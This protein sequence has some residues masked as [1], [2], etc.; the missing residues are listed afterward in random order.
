MMRH[1]TETLALVEMIKST[2]IHIKYIQ[3]VQNDFGDFGVDL[4]DN[5]MTRGAET[6]VKVR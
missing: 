4:H 2:H 1:L 3:K 5:W 6:K